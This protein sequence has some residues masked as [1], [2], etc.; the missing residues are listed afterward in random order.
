MIDFPSNGKRL[1]NNVRSI[2]LKSVH[3]FDAQSYI[4]TRRQGADLNSTPI[5]IK[6]LEMYLK[7]K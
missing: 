4:C 5:F 6:L 1:M 7:F 3:K 2:A